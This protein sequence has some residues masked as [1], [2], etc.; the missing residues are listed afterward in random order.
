[1]NVTNSRFASIRSPAHSPQDNVF[2]NQGY[3]SVWRIAV[4][5]RRVP[6][7][8]GDSGVQAWL[9]EQPAQDDESTVW[10]QEYRRRLLAYA[11]EQVRASFEDATWQA[12]W[13]TAA[14]GKP[15]KEVAAS[16][17]MT[18]GAVDIA[19]SRVLSRITD[20][21]RQLLDE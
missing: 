6:R 9:E 18:V 7:G 5:L 19:K 15:G 20:Q 11:A 4:K 17:G 16:L 10:D 14:L 2:S 1:M 13:Q 21:V 8:S 3:P 12:F